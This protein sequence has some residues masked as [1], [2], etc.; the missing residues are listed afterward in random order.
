MSDCIIEAR[1]ITF[2]YL[3]GTTALNDLSI[4]I[5]NGKKIAVIGNNGAGKTTLFLHFNGVHRPI[6][7]DIW[8]KG[9]KLNY[10]SKAIREIRKNVGIVFQDPD[11]QL[12]SASVYQDVSFGPLNLGWDDKKVRE[13][14]ETAM[15][16]TGTW[17]LK[18]KPTHFLSY[19]QKKRVAI[20]GILAMEPQIIIL[21]EPTAGLDPVYCQ[22][23]LE[24]L[25]QCNQS[26]AATVLISSHNMDE[27]YS[28]ADLVFVMHHGQIIGEGT[29]IEVFSNDEVLKKASLNKPWILRVY[30]LV[31]K[32]K[33]TIAQSVPRTPDELMEEIKN[34]FI[35]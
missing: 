7:G 27:V 18:D 11:I 3:D 31:I 5:P 35:K 20:A 14:V 22:Q 2:K 33:A 19:G 9:E 16:R 24:L 26:G 30:E 32:G 23:M 10:N 12:F 13:K 17:E 15:R 8:F 34:V 29:P 1:N 6:N 4:K 28:W 25:N 21:D